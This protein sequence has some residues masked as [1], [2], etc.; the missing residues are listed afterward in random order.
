V[1]TV[2]IELTAR[3]YQG[4]DDLPIIMALH[5]ACEAVDRLG[6]PQTLSDLRESMSEPGFDPGV[7]VRLWFDQEETLVA[8][9]EFWPPR[10]PEAAQLHPAAFM[11][12][13]VLPEIR[14]IGVEEQLIIWA[15]ERL[16]A[17]VR[18]QGVPLLLE[19][20]A[21]DVETQRQELLERLGF[22]TIRYFLRMSRPLDQIPAPKLPA[23][24]R[25][26][27]GELSNEDYVELRNAVWVDHFGYQPWTIEDPIF[28][29]SSELN[30]P[31]LDLIAMTEDGQPVGFCWG[32]I[33]PEEQALLGLKVGWIGILGVRREY[34]GSG[35]GRALL[36]EA[37]HR[38]KAR[39]CDYA[40]LGVDGES[41]TK[42]TRLYLAEGFEEIYVRKLYAR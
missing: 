30:D 10:T 20:A 9:A 36:R 19:I 40:R 21:R 12:M 41:P 33:D 23:G 3:A 38:L 31:E 14:G 18:Q 37:L 15:Q 11:W 2:P 22:Q 27:A 4:E 39:G 35:V 42:A 24:M 8:Y 25:V 34:R 7:N 13:T 32:H 29:R 28:Y 5:A 26:V 1:T 16:E 17:T 6:E